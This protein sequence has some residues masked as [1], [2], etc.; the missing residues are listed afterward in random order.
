MKSF[1][2]LGLSVVAAMLLV[3]TSCLNGN[4]TSS[5]IA[6]G[7][8][9]Y[10]SS[11]QPVVHT[12]F[13]DVVFPSLETRMDDGYCAFYYTLD[14]EVQDQTKPYYQ[15]T[16]GQYL[17]I[18]YSGDIRFIYSNDELQV[19]ENEQVCTECN[20]IA[21]VEKKL[22]IAPVL[23]GIVDKQTTTYRM[24]YNADSVTV[25]GTEKIYNLY[26]KAVRDKTGEPSTTMAAENTVF[27]IATFWRDA[28]NK[29]GKENI[30]FKIKFVKSIDKNTKEMTW[31][32][33][34]KITI[35]NLNNDTS[36]NK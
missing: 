2:F 35:G 7:V 21:L 20:P 34:E 29:E 31:G 4:N 23:N 10:N 11:Y 9:G 14:Q 27:D 18:P 5:G 32:E 6:Y 1:K 12:M 19:Q 36:T 16:I 25:N 30:N 15:V 26:V 28:S 33:T 22:F 24:Y 8:Y 13:G 3:L 17:K